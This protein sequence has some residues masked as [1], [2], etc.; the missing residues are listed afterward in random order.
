MRKSTKALMALTTAALLSGPGATATAQTWRETL[1][2]Q[3]VINASLASRDA[4]I[5]SKTE[6]GARLRRE[7]G[8][9]GQERER[10]EDR[11]IGTA[12][13]RTLNR[14]ENAISPQL[15]RE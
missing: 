6:D 5:D 8:Q 9:I 2:P 13:D 4:R 1:P 11:Q 15:R 3:A 7:D 12:E 10:M 14:P